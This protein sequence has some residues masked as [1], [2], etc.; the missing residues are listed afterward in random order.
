MQLGGELVLIVK[1]GEPLHL[2][3]IF[4]VK[5]RILSKTA[6]K[7]VSGSGLVIKANSDK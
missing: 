4:K 7:M 5:T 3:V 6:P 1:T 2:D